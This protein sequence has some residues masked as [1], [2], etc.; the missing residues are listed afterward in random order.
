MANGELLEFCEVKAEDE[1]GIY[2]QA[3]LTPEAGEK[4]FIPT[5]LEQS[6]Y[7]YAADI[8]K[9]EFDLA[10]DLVTSNYRSG[11]K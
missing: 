10:R 4:R 6:S 8:M 3:L 9:E 5:S 7:E 1:Q 11:Q 2:V